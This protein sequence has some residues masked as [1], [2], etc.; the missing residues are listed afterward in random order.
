MTRSR[1]EWRRQDRKLG[2]LLDAL[3]SLGLSASTAVVFHSDHGYHLGEGGLWRK[4][5]N[6]ELATR[7]PLIIRAPAAP[8]AGGSGAPRTFDRCRSKL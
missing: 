1:G 8:H 4:M 7:V 5:T 6:F 2:S 3:D